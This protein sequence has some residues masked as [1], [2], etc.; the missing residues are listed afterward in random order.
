MN[1]E[2]NKADKEKEE[3][4]KIMKLPDLRRRK[5][6]IKLFAKK[7]ILEKLNIKDQMTNDKF[8]NYINEADIDENMRD[9]INKYFG[10]Y[11]HSEYVG[12]FSL[13][14]D[15]NQLVEDTKLFLSRITS[16]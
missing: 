12:N 16:Y 1:K 11:G 2:E 15:V 3:F 13:T 8:K 4:E 7:K 6:N 14:E 10:D 9:E 5:I